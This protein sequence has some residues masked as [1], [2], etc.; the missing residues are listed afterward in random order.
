[1][2]LLRNL[3]ILTSLFLNLIAYSASLKTSQCI[4]DS[5]E[6]SFSSL[7][8]ILAQDLLEEALF[9]AKKACAKFPKNRDLSYYKARI[10][11][12]NKKQEDSLQELKKWK[13]DDFE[14]NILKGDIH[15]YQGDCEKALEFYTKAKESLLNRKES[16][17]YQK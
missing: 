2:D 10:L 8:K 12:W 4:T 13:S 14:T 1:M 16:D 5:E 15:W 11:A 7:K 17:Y 9:C 6:L 3:I